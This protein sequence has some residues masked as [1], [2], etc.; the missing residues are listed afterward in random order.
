MSRAPSF[1]GARPTA[2]GNIVSSVAATAAS[3]FRSAIPG[4]PYLKEIVSPCSVSCRRP[5]TAPGGC[6]STAAY[7]GP[8]PRPAE[9]PRPWKSVSSTPRSVA[10]AASSS[11]AR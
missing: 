1:G 2:S 11:C 8:P 9:P 5:A 6:A 3:R 4:R 10:S 7:V